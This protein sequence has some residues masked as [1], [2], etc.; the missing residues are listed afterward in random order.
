MKID[1][2]CH[3]G[4]LFYEAEIDPDKVRVC[5]CID[6]QIL[7]G[8]AFRTA[9]HVA[10]DQ[11]NLLRGTPKTYVKTGGSG[12]P[13]TMVFCGTCGTQLYGTGDGDAAKTLSLRVGTCNQR[14]DLTPQRQIWRR[15]AVKWLNDLGIADSHEMGT[16]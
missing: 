16:G 8:A 12:R 9:V 6:C 10:V 3:C 4:E 5:H 11:F 2:G 7:S 13:R 14:A 15:S 1:G